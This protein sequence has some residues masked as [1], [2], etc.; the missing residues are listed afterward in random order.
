MDIIKEFIA[1]LGAK[2]YA[3][4]TRRVYIAA[5]K[6]ALRSVGEKAEKWQSPEKFLSTLQEN[7]ARE[8]FPSRLRIAPFLAFIISK[9]PQISKKVPDYGP[10][11]NWVLGRIEDETKSMRK[12]SIQARRD[13]AMLAA[14]CVAPEKGS[15]RSWPKGALAV[16]KQGGSLR[17]KLWNK[18]VK[19]PGLA[20]ALLYWSTWRN[21][22]D[23][24][25]QSRIYRK[26]WAHSDL[27]FPDSKGGKMKKWAMHDA[28]ARLALKGEEVVVFPTP[29]LVR[30]AFL[31]LEASNSN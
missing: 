17:V 9:T 18:E 16:E 2:D 30:Q 22:L 10:L 21:R 20:M 26:D 27:L 7:M 24:P 28:L 12:P 29:E 15:P 31:Q 25:D 14:V 1:F 6:R 4:S 3:P 13:L 5:A 11:R 19:T 23:R 8:S